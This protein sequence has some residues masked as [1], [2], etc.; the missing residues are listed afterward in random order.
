ME[1]NRA[2]QLKSLSNFAAPHGVRINPAAIYP[3]EESI[4]IITGGK[5]H[6]EVD[7]VDRVFEAGAI[8]WHMPGEYTVHRYPL[9]DPYRC[10]AM[11]FVMAEARRALPRITYWKDLNTLSDFCRTAFRYGH[12]ERIDNPVLAAM[13]YSRVFWESYMYLK[14]EAEADL[15]PHLDRA[16]A[17][18]NRDYTGELLIETVAQRAGISI[19]NL[20]S[21]FKR[22][23]NTTPHQY[24][25]NLRLRRAR[26]LLASNEKSIKEI[27][28]ESG[29]E[30]LESFYRAFRKNSQMTPAEFR[31]LNMVSEY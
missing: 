11:R 6:F 23:L 24:L 9:D 16:L 12:D 21:L 7:G 1:M 26:T 22:Y 2:V 28:L 14:K 25:L 3:G 20:Y 30:N 15:P 19:P 10:L 5:V 31:R 29:F 17:I 13:L 27:S 18:M 8:F 4:E